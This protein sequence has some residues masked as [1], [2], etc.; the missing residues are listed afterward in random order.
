MSMNMCNKY[1]KKKTHNTLKRHQSGFRIV[2][3]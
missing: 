3:S 2:Q 1:E